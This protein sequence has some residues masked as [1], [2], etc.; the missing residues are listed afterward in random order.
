VTASCLDSRVFLG[1]V[2]W[3]DRERIRYCRLPCL[4]WFFTFLLCLSAC[5]IYPFRA[6]A[7]LYRSRAILLVGGK[8][9]LSSIRRFKSH[10]AVIFFGRRTFCTILDGIRS[11]SAITRHLFTRARRKPTK[12]L[13]PTPH[14]STAKS[15][16]QRGRRRKS[17]DGRALQHPSNLSLLY[18]TY[19]RR[20]RHRR[21]DAACAKP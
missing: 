1:W 11:A 12:K 19:R 16:P 15:P 18:S 10:G 13:P 21:G 14:R 17:G 8:K 7:V 4:V 20:C 5:T 6:A 3:L 9:K 2:G